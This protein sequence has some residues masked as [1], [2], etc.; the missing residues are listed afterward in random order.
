MVPNRG[1]WTV[2]QKYLS[3]ADATIVNFDRQPEERVRRSNQCGSCGHIDA[4]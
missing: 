4:W 3:S 1:S 2:R